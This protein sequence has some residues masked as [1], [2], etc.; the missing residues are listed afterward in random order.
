MTE[1]KLSIIQHALGCDKYGQTEYRG[2][3]EGDGCFSYYR[4]R[5]VTDPGVPEIEALIK[6]GL[7]E[8]LGPVKMYSGMHFY[9]VTKAGV[10]AMKAQSPKLSRAERRYRDYLRADTGQS[11]GQWIK[12]KS[13]QF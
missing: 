11:F 5:Y 8:D 2:R 10:E 3:D 1:N 7:M 13:Y 4:N 6:D 9:R 12:S